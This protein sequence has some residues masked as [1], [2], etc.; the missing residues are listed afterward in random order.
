MGMR[1]N[2]DQ[3][4]KKKY[5]H[6]ILLWETYEGL[7]FLVDEFMLKIP[8]II[9]ELV[10]EVTYFDTFP[11][12]KIARRES[13]IY[14]LRTAEAELDIRT[15]NSLGLRIKGKKHNDVHMLYLMIRGGQ[16]RPD[17]S[18]EGKQIGFSRV[19]LEEAYAE[20]LA[21]KGELK[22]ALNETRQALQ[23][24]KEEVDGVRT[25]WYLSKKI[26]IKLERA[27]RAFS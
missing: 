14:R 27:V 25:P 21:D 17:E 16:I 10:V 23:Q 11:L 15:E 24:L 20:A 5:F 8:E 22:V 13:G 1:K 3:G 26:A 6:G 12:K 9:K 2:R 4:A 18:W 19:E 7:Y